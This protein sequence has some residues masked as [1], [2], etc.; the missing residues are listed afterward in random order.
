MRRNKILYLL[1]IIIICICLVSCGNKN[2]DNPG[3]GG[4]YIAYGY[5]DQFNSFRLIVRTEEGYYFMRFPYLYFFDLLTSKIVPVCS[6]PDCFH[7]NSG[8]D[9][10]LLSLHT[11]GQL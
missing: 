9:A 8:C 11:S 10:N 3:T 5:D 6:K 1:L 4:R 2:N 7:N